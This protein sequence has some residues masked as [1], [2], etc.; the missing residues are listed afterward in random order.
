MIFKQC[1]LEWWLTRPIWLQTMTVA[2]RRW[3][4]PNGTSSN[5]LPKKYSCDC[6]AWPCC[7]MSVRSIDCLSSRSL[8]SHFHTVRT[9][10]HRTGITRWQLK[11]SLS[12]VHLRYFREPAFSKDCASSVS[13]REEVDSNGVVLASRKFR[14]ATIKETRAMGDKGRT[15]P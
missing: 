6:S 15:S 9:E 5:T 7:S 8:R 12:L 14:Q 11:R 4:I 2:S 13:H 3:S 10:Q 1:F